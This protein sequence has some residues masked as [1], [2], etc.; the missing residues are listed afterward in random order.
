MAFK[1]RQAW[2]QSIWATNSFLEVM[3]LSGQLEERRSITIWNNLPPE[4]KL[5][6]CLDNFKC[7][8]KKH[9]LRDFLQ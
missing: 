2:L 8:L 7:N 5:S 9:L 4:I 3:Y 6:Q 1:C